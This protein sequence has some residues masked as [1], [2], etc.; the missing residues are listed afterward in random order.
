MTCKERNNGFQCT[1]PEGHGGVNHVVYDTHG[2]AVW[3]WPAVALPEVPFFRL[4]LKPGQELSAL[5]DIHVLSD[6][7]ALRIQAEHNKLVYES[8]KR[9]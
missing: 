5:D 7:E 6:K 8:L 9:N 4:N 1:L 3:T 2:D